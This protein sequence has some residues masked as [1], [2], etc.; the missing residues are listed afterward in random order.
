MSVTVDL[1]VENRRT[2]LRPSAATTTGVLAAIVAAPIFATLLAHPELKIFGFNDWWWHRA[3]ADHASLWPIRPPYAPHL[4]FHVSA[5]VLSVIIGL[6]S[7]SALVGAIAIGA[8]VGGAVMLFTRRADGP[9]LIGLAVLCALAFAFGESPSVAAF[10]HQIL[11]GVGPLPYPLPGPLQRWGAPT[12]IVQLPFIVVML[13]LIVRSCDLARS[14]ATPRSSKWALLGVT[15]AGT[16]ARPSVTLAVLPAVLVWLALSRAPRE[17]WRF[18]IR[19]AFIPGFSIAAAQTIWMSTQ[20]GVQRPAPGLEVAHQGIRLTSPIAR[21]ESFGWTEG[22][23]GYWLLLALP[24]LCAIVEPSRYLA[25]RFIRITLISLPITAVPALLL[26]EV[27]NRG[28]GGGN[29]LTAFLHV[30]LVM[31]V[32]FTYR[33]CVEAAADTRS[34]RRTILV[35]GT[36][37]YGL[38]SIW[39]GTLVLANALA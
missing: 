8:T 4:L 20:A 34:W 23:L 21:I 28:S 9:A 31:L 5:G 10:R 19:W 24:L 17:V 14:A 16:L 35:A 36:V 26:Q 33:F 3:I 22:H 7:A 1:L 30:S 37:V 38:T 12:H 29:E 18:I 27:D 2:R 13:P 32:L 25:D 39:S 15:V 6:D 11:D